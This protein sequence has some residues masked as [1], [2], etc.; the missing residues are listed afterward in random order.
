[1]DKRVMLLTQILMTLMM[2]ISMS[3]LMSAFAM[4]LTAEWLAAWPLSALIA[5]PIAFVLTQGAFPLANL[6][7]RKLLPPRGANKGA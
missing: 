5:W 6:M 4:G 1:M 2:A 3:G 7:A